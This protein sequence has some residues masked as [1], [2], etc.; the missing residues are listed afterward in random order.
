MLAQLRPDEQVN[1]GQRQVPT[2]GPLR[3]EQPKKTTLAKRCHA[4]WDYPSQGYIESLKIFFLSP[5]G[6]GGGG[7]GG[8]AIK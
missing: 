8:G 6:G 7:G 5:I 1:V 2:L 3:S 4:I